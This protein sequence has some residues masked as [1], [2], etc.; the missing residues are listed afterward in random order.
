MIS[1]SEYAELNKGI[2]KWIGKVVHEIVQDLY[3]KGVRH[4]SYS[5]SKEAI[6]LLVHGTLKKRYGAP[7]RLGIIFPKHLVFVKYGVG[8]NRAKG[9]GK[10]TPKDIVDNIIEK[11]LPE[12]ADIVANA[13]GDI[14][15]KN[16]FIDK[17]RGN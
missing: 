1:S 11:N 14:V 2:R 6:F 17:S 8:K 13:W 3:A 12:L 9:S 7:E 15:V 10:E 5:N 4:R 16:I